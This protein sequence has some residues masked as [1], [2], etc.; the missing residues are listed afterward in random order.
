MPKPSLDIGLD[1]HEDL[2]ISSNYYNVNIE[3]RG[4]QSE[5]FGESGC[6]AQSN[7]PLKSQRENDPN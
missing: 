5:S 6:L 4:G 2:D 3:H 1:L 7:N